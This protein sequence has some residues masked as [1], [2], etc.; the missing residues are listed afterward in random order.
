MVITVTHRG[1]IKRVP[2]NTYR[3]QKRGG[4][5]RKA[6]AT[7]EE[8]FVNQVFVANTKSSATIFFNKRKSLSNESF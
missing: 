5:G 7:R 4:K 2:L 8:D 6:M 3:A 1:Y